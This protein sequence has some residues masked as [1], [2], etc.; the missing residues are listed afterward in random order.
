MKTHASMVW[1]A[2]EVA[3]T[4]LGSSLGQSAPPSQLTYCRSLLSWIL[5]GCSRPEGEPTREVRKL[6]GE[7][8][9]AGLEAAFGLNYRELA[10][11]SIHVRR[12][13]L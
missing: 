8:V 10:D 6:V 9:V 11:A 1:N 13:S 2:L 4:Q 3:R 5:T 7:A 12:Q